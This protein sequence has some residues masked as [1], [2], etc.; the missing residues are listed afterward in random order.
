MSISS[1]LEIYESDNKQLIALLSRDFKDLGQ[2]EA[3]KN[4]IAL[5]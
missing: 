5:T 4:P 1:Y 3:I 2:Y